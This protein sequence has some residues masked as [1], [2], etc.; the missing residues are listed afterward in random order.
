MSLT[1][2]QLCALYLL[3]GKPSDEAARLAGYE[4]GIAHADAMRIYRD[5]RDMKGHDTSWVKPA[6][7]DKRKQLNALVR[8]ERATEVL[9]AL[10]TEWAKALEE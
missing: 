10:E 8:L 7:E 2:A 4:W 1:K 9:D 3:L 5:A 6:I